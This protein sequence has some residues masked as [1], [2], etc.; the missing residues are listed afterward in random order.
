MVN[1]DNDADYRTTLRAFL[2]FPGRELRHFVKAECLEKWKE[3]A[4][5]ELGGEAGRRAERTFEQGEDDEDRT[6]EPPVREVENV[7]E[8]FLEFLLRTASVD[9]DDEANFDHTTALEAFL[10][11]VSGGFANG[12]EFEQWQEAAESE[13]RE[14]R[15]KTWM[16]NKVR[17][18][19][20]EGAGE[21]G[22]A[23][24]L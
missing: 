4:E 18:Q 24:E 17:Q 22:E 19:G 2:E 6:D 12:D 16:E 7:S 5:R 10:E 3:D 20:T 21:R 14:D 9:L 23:D 13:L 8:A 15:F 11:S 1:D